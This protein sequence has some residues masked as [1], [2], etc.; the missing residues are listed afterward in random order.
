MSKPVA[1]YL[2]VSLPQSVG[3]EDSIQLWLERN[4]NG[5]DVTVTPYK[6]PK[7]KV[8]TLDSLVEQSDE[9]SKYDT[10]LYQSILK[11]LEI[12]G[13]VQNPGS[14]AT[15]T[16]PV[17]PRMKLDGKTV[18]AY[19]E[20]F[21]WNASRYRLDKPIDELI[22]SISDEALSL[23]SDVK[24]A[25]S[26]YT[27]A[28]SNLL[29][30]QRKQNGDLTVRSLHDLVNKDDFV[31]GSEHLVTEL[32]VV[33]KSVKQQFLDSYETLAPFV[34]PRSA[35]EITEDS[36]YYLYGV[37]VFGK[38]EQQFLNAA[39]EAKFIPREFDYS[40]ENIN[41]MKN[42]FAEASKTETEQRN[43]LIRLTKSA[44]TEL[45]SAWMHIKILRT[46][47]ESV[48]RYGLPPD[49]YCY[50]LRLKT[51]KA[52]SRAKKDLVTRFGYLGGNAFSTDKNGKLVNDSSLHD[53]ASLVDTDYEPFVLYLVQLY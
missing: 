5:G 15:S 20:G 13:N 46:F 3:S 30:A 49:F 8:G 17:L 40:E 14:S 2:L 4:V 21:Q 36:E 18:D 9:L 39:R 44:Y 50:F 45:S 24:N 28:R 37:T 41:Q 10:Q 7:F 23:D 33:P 53:Y 51:D 26:T 31:L 29:A 52:I 11:D 48:L 32:V 16:S 19:F 27:A 12:T 34:V 35:H 1:E 22:K 47:V 42:E 25:Y 38:Y 6:L 43:D